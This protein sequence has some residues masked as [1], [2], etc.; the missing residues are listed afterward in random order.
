MFKRT[1]V[2]LLPLLIAACS[3]EA[4]PTSS[5]VLPAP[6]ETV[7]VAALPSPSPV[8]EPSSTP[9]S[10]VEF[11]SEC[12]LVSSLPEAPSEFAELFGIT[13][14]DWVDGPDTAALTIVEY[15]DF[16]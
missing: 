3:G 8:V 15:G 9:E 7:A 12:T 11:V 5:A 10:N 2:L 4:E 16:Q 6:T 1:Y 14:G 13:G